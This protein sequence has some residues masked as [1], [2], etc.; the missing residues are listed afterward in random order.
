[1]A[2]VTTTIDGIE[3]TFELNR[4]GDSILNTA[5]DAGVDAPFSCKGGVCT[6][7]MAKLQEGTVH[8]DANYALTDKEVSNGFILCC[9]SHPTSDVVK[10]TWDI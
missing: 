7:C 10:L 5:L 2:I 8:M 1:M 3:T 4:D 6:T 9:Q